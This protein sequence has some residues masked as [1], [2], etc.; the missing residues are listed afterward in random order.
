MRSYW[1]GRSVDEVKEP[2]APPIQNSTFF[3]EDPK[4]IPAGV[5]V[6]GLTK[7]FS[8]L[9]KVAVNKLDLNTCNGQIT[10]LLGHNGAGKTTTMSMLTGLFPPTSGTALVG[11]HDIVR[12]MDEVRRSLGLCPQHDILFDDLTVAEHITFFSKVRV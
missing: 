11:G 12:E 1:L 10:M 2:V 8:R 9:N 5:Q 7:V 3:E 6:Q 4:G